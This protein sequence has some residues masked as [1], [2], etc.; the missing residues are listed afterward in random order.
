MIHDSGLS[1]RLFLIH[2]GAV[3]VGLTL[4]GG[5]GV[6]AGETPAAESPAEPSRTIAGVADPEIRA[7]VEAA[8]VKN[9]IPAAVE[10]A[11]PGYFWISAAV[12]M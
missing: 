4:A 12:R 7:G 1:R 2:T 10:T 6:L 9:M 5:K 8:I 3:G 11:Y